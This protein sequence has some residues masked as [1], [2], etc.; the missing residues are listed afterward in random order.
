MEN[1]YEKQLEKVERLT[2][3]LMTLETVSHHLYEDSTSLMRTYLKN[4]ID[5]CKF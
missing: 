1:L 5:T 4:S 2:K 3:T